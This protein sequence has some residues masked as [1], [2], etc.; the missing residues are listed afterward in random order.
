MEQDKPPQELPWII[1]AEVR[2]DQAE[3][4]VAAQVAWISELRR[5]HYD[6]TEATAVLTALTDELLRCY[7]ELGLHRAGGGW[8]QRRRP[9][10][11]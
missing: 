10:D 9:P 1:E 3:A 5:L 4:Q 7:E 11:G 6:T 8:R 2:A